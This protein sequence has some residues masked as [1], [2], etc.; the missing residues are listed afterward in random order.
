M[1]EP[2]LHLPR[3]RK[4]KACESRLAGYIQA[5]PGGAPALR[6][7]GALDRISIEAAPWYLERLKFL[8]HIL[9]PIPNEAYYSLLLLTSE[10]AFEAI[11]TAV[12][13][14]AKEFDP[15]HAADL[16]LRVGMLIQGCA[17]GKEF[18]QQYGDG[19]VKAKQTCE[20]EV[21][22]E[23]VDTQTVSA[24]YRNKE[25]GQHRHRVGILSALLAEAAGGSPR[26]IS[27]LAA[28]APLHDIGKIG[29]PDSI[30]GKR[31]KLTQ[32][33][34]NRMKSHTVIGAR[35]LG[36]SR[37]AVLQMASE[38]AL[39]HHERWDGTG[40]PQGLAGELIPLPARITAIADVFDALTHDRPYKKAWSS[41]KAMEAI[42]QESGGH[43]DPALVC[44]FLSMVWSEDTPL[45]CYKAGFD[46]RL[47]K[48]AS[49]I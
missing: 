14:G 15:I 8:E 19:E 2:K 9:G 1:P 37:F 4:A 20:A 11:V 41:E 47:D 6:A 12:L 34:F 43:F 30:L 7:E 17:P 23:I 46:H 38:I 3:T 33:E 22:V 5:A 36:W 29:V 32:T 28:T 18:K 49:T 27:L 35:I 13:V 45:R 24:A 31:T 40:Y 26:D 16:L 48:V 42:K 44:A 21:R 10:G 25:I 39:S